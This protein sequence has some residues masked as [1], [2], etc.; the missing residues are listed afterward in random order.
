ML[1]T[2]HTLVGLALS[3]SGLGRGVPRA[4]W[5]VVVAANFPDIDIL[6]GRGDG[7]RYL[8]YHRGFTHSLLGVLLGS[9][10][11]SLAL[12]AVPAYRRACARTGTRFHTLSVTVWLVMLTHPLLDF[13]NAYGL[14]PFIP[15][16]YRWYA[17]NTVSVVNLHLD[18]ALLFFLLLGLVRKSSRWPR[19]ALVWVLAYWT[20]LHVMHQRA[21]GVLARSTVSGQRPQDWAAFPP[22]LQLDP[23]RWEGVFETQ[24]KIYGIR[25]SSHQEAGELEPRWRFHKG[26]DHAAVPASRRA[27]TVR[28]FLDFARFPVPLVEESPDGY[29]VTWI[30]LRGYQPEVG[31]AFSAQVQFSK[32]LRIVAQDFR[33]RRETRRNSAVGTGGKR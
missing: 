32:D 8:D 19:A 1:N 24:E 18:L 21:E 11:L 25:V 17:W 26:L 10:A 16:S 7:A 3:R 9:F 31:R 29:V 30:D 28:V 15:F 4:G 5:I 33:F 22:L 12:W 14:R 23:G 27:Y 2:T 20:A 6:I 13:T